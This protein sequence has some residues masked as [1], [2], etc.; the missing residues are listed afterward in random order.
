MTHINSI[1][2]T[3]SDERFRTLVEEYITMQRKDFTFKGVCPY[4]LH[5]V[6]DEGCVSVRAEEARSL[7]RLQPGSTESQT[8]NYMKATSYH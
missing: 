8:T 4:I 7:C 1:S 6:M 5:R 2:I 3:Y